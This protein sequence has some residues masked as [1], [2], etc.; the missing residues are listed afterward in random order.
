L[1]LKYSLQ[2]IQKLQTSSRPERPQGYS[3]GREA[4][5]CRNTQLSPARTTQYIGPED[6]TSIS[7]PKLALLAGIAAYTHQPKKPSINL[8]EQDRTLLLAA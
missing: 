7:Y 4:W 1:G 2:N 8:V 3:P 6:V 5:V